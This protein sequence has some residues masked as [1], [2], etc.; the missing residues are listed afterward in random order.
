MLNFLYL[1]FNKLNITVYNIKHLFKLLNSTC[2]VHNSKPGCIK[3]LYSVF[4]V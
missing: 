2:K 4:A 3:S 1:L